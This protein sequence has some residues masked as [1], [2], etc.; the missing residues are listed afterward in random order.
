MVAR[1]LEISSRCGS[2]TGH[3]GMTASMW[4]PESTVAMA[5]AGAAARAVVTTSCGVS[6]PGAA[7][8]TQPSR[9]VTSCFAV[10]PAA[11][12]QRCRV[13]CAASTWAAAGSGVTISV[14]PVKYPADPAGY[15]VARKVGAG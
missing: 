6:R 7:T 9:S 1:P 4:A 13:R 14:P 2:S 8:A 15:S 3:S 12:G 5:C 10:R 11:S